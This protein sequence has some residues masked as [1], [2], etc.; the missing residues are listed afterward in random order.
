MTG[1]LQ[2]H[3][4]KYSIPIDNLTFTFEVTNAFQQLEI[5]E[6]QARQDGAYVYGLYIEGARWDKDKRGL[7]DAFPM[8]MFSVDFQ[9]TNLSNYP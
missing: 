1:L 3:A 9:T 2:N 4:R 6:A 8:D 5:D 7:E